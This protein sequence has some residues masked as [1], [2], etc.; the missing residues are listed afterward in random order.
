MWLVR[1]FAC[2][3][4]RRERS[5]GHGASTSRGDAVAARRARMEQQRRQQQE[6]G[7][8]QEA[9]DPPSGDSA[10]SPSHLVVESD[11]GQR[12]YTACE[13]PRST[14]CGC[15]LLA[16]THQ[17]I[18]SSHLLHH[19]GSTRSRT[20]R[21]RA[22]YRAC[23]C[24]RCRARSRAHAR[25]HAR[26]HGR[27]HSTPACYTHGARWHAVRLLSCTAVQLSWGAR[28]PA[29]RVGVADARDEG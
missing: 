24:A 4:A 19:R 6:G 14:T 7:T 29:V 9:T 13:Q 1:C 2:L 20:R 17:F 21:Y 15:G 11:G 22:C 3:Q 5:R 10:C 16:N 18:L 23:C 28:A 26:A 27:T 25:A 12:R 8:G